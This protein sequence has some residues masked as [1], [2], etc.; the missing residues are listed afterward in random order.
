MS[1]IKNM[2]FGAWLTIFPAALTLS[3]CDSDSPSPPVEY[4]PPT[5]DNNQECVDL[6]GASWYCDLAASPHVCK[7]HADGDAEEQTDGDRDAAVD[8]D[9]DGDGNDIDG[10][11]GVLYGPPPCTSAEDC[12]SWHGNPDSGK[13]WICD[14]NSGNCSQQLIGGDTDSDG[15]STYYGPLSCVKK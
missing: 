11:N 12:Q 15:P 3:G 7:Q 8:G 2:I 5:C 14:T 10:D 1:W 6:N 9:H 13:E 4:G